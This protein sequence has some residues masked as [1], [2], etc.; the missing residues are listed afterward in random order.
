MT[1]AYSD[2]HPTL[3]VVHGRA[4]QFSV[5]QTA[6]SPTCSI[7]EKPLTGFDD[8]HALEKGCLVFEPFAHLV[9]FLEHLSECTAG[10][11]PMRR[12]VKTDDIFASSDLGCGLLA[13]AS[14]VEVGGL[15]YVH[16]ELEA[17]VVGVV[18]GILV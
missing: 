18:V 17:D 14:S 7:M 13:S 12:E 11:A 8:Y 6:Q 15:D 1:V 4:N 9:E 16:L 3:Y 5:G 2:I 10:R